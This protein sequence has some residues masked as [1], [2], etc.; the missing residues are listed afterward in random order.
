MGT[1][2]NEKLRSK[3]FDGLYVR[4]EK[5]QENGPHTGADFSCIHHSRD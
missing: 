2:I 1:C 3:D 5:D 4:D